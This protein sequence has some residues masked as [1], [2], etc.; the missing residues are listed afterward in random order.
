VDNVERSGEQ[1][2]LLSVELLHAPH[3]LAVDLLRIEWNGELV[4][5]I[6]CPFR[7]AMPSITVGASSCQRPP[8][9][10][11][12]CSLARFQSCSESRRTPSRSNITASGRGYAS[13]GAPTVRALIDATAPGK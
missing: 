7:R 5:Q 1:R 9:Q 4:V 3:D 2:Q 13:H 10:R 11:V 8:E 12:S 6:A